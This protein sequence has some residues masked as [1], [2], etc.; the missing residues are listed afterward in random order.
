MEVAGL[1]DAGLL[2]ILMTAEISAAGLS[3]R[4]FKSG[5]I[6]KMVSLIFSLV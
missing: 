5:S 3:S 1:A 4:V 2:G 6:F